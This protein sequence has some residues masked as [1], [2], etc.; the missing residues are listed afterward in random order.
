MR[1]VLYVIVLASAGTWAAFTL[2]YAVTRPFWRSQYGRNM[3][4]MGASL[5]TLLGSFAWSYWITPI[6]LTV[7][8]A[9]A[10][11]ILA[12]GVHRLWLLQRTPPEIRRP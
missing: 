4:G 7:W 9:I 11:A 12:V 5:A 1:T 2:I 8:G 3:F 10:T 6:P